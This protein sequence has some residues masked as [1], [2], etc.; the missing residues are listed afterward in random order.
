MCKYL[1]SVSKII[2]KYGFANQIV[3]VKCGM[4][5]ASE[6]DYTL[7]MDLKNKLLLSNVRVWIVNVTR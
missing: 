3:V 4:F 5:T 1:L 6:Q 2:F 7:S